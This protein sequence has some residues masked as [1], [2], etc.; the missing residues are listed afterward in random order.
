MN[1]FLNI[2][3]PDLSPPN[4]SVLGMLSGRDEESSDSALIARACGDGEREREWDGEEDMAR[5][6]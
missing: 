3:Q 2:G 1:F 6:G 4:L 5:L